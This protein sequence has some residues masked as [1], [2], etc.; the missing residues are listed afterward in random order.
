MKEEHN[1]ADIEAFIELLQ[2]CKDKLPEDCRVAVH[3]D[4][5]LDKERSCLVVA[6]FPTLERYVIN[7]AYEV[8]GMQAVDNKIKLMFLLGVIGNCIEKKFYDKFKERLERDINP[9]L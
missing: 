8:K 1:T 9:I 3:R 5:F 4:W 6:R 2:W 7:A